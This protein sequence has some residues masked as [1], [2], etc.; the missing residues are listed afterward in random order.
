MASNFFCVHFSP[1][2]KKQQ[3]SLPKRT[4]SFYN[5]LYVSST[6]FDDQNNFFSYYFRL[7]FGADFFLRLKSLWLIKFRTHRSSKCF[8]YLVRLWWKSYSFK[9]KFKEI[10]IFS[11]SHFFWSCRSPLQHVQSNL[12]LSIFAFLRSAWIW[13]RLCV[14]HYLAS[15]FAIFSVFDKVCS[16]SI[17]NTRK[18]N[19][20]KIKRGEW[21]RGKKV[22]RTSVTSHLIQD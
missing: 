18:K 22:L 21:E 2:G 6:L 10:K 13:F 9:K 20:L 5:S 17:K 16:D 12:F 8:E 19:I 11:S 14:I 3:Y 4:E 7:H 1:P 15:L